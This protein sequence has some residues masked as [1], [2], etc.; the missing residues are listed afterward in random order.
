MGFF[1]RGGWEGNGRAALKGVHEFFQL[2]NRLALIKLSPTNRSD[3]W[4]NLN[5]PHFLWESWFLIYLLAIV[6]YKKRKTQI[7]KRR[8]GLLP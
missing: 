3:G 8:E 2:P 1:W 7:G 4:A 6:F 5:S